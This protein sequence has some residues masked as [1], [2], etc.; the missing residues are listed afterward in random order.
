M[1]SFLITAI[2]YVLLLIA[3]VHAYLGHRDHIKLT[4]ENKELH[5]Q[6]HTQ[7]RIINKLRLENTKVPDKPRKPKLP[8]WRRI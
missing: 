6:V 4:R 2:P 7:A 5:E 8:W 1:K 3:V